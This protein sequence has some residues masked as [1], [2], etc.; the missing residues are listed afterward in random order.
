MTILKGI[1]IVAG[2]AVL[3]AGGAFAWSSFN[4]A[5]NIVSHSRL[6]RLEV[7]LLNDTCEMCHRRESEF[8]RGNVKV[9]LA[10]PAWK[11]PVTCTDCHDFI[12][13]EPVAQK[14][15]ECHTASYLI[16]LT[17]WTTGFD[18]ELALIDKK[19]KRAESALARAPREDVLVT[20]A[21]RLVKEAREGLDLVKR[22]IGAHHPDAA[23]ALLAVANQKAEKAL[24]IAAR[25]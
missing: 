4:R 12:R 8:Y 22:P 15:V 5:Q 2:M 16:Y 10:R 25:R 7:G 9:S 18:E 17:E 24:A 20:R 1:F 13:K 23:R 14:C 21:K 19:L 3:V 11:G 6:T